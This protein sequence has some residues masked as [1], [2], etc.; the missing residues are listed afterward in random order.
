MKTHIE[1]LGGVWVEFELWLGDIWIFLGW[2]IFKYNS[3]MISDGNGLSK[4]PRYIVVGREEC[5]GKVNVKG[6]SYQK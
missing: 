5:R 4:K 1:N 3:N 2:T 6:N